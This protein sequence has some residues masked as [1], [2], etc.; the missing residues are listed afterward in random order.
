[1]AEEGEEKVD[2]TGA[3]GTAGA[4][5]GPGPAAAAPA[6]FKTLTRSRS[7]RMVAGVAGGLGRYFGLDPL[8]FRL[9]FAFLTLLGGAGLALYVAAWLLVPEEGEA[10]SVGEVAAEKASAYVGTED[11][12]WIWITATVI[13]GLILISNLDS[14]HY[15]SAWFW[16]AVLIAGGIWLYRQDAAQAR[17]APLVPPPSPAE[18]GAGPV[19]AAAPT[20]PPA[21]AANHPLYSPPPRPLTPPVPKPPASSLPRYTFAMTL[22]A[23]GIAAMLDNGGALDVTGAE[24]AAVALTTV[25]AGLVVGSVAGRARG[26]IF[27]G[28][29]LSLFVV[30]GNQADIPYR[31]GMGDRTYRP[32]SAE[33]LSGDYEMFAGKL[34]F[35]FSD[36]QW[37]EPAEL[38]TELVF[39]SI[40]IVV[41][42]GVDVRFTGKAEIG[43]LELFDQQR[44]GQDISLTSEDD[45]GTSPELTI[46][47]RV[48]TGQITVNRGGNQ[49]GGLT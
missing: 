38:N 45:S 14:M 39:G 2:S 43:S 25:G 8:L 4:D 42:E 31:G 47:A 29:L 46:D 18:A 16:G 32:L 6:S 44:K 36:M 15:S 41:P 11:R 33:E 1:M 40:E 20:T 30:V 27:W 3:N 22:V 24:Y 17:S 35:D 37:N 19:G 7:E 28:L 23:L 48:F 5:T 13:G 21:G 26:L 9:A 49:V 34:R 10:R 12:S